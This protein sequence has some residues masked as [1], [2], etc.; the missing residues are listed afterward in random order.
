MIVHKTNVL[1]L[2]IVEYLANNELKSTWKQTVVAYY[3]TLYRYL[4]GGTGGNHG[5]L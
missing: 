1:T 5:N 4:L 3:E 2:Q